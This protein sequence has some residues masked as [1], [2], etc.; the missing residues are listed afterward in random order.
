M[1]L[2]DL[3]VL[4]TSNVARSPLLAELLRAAAERRGQSEVAIASAGVDA[5]VGEPA[6]TGSRR[7]AQALGISLEGH[8]SMPVMMVDA[9]GASLVLVMSRAHRTD[10][11]RRYPDLSGRTFTLREL[12]V[13]LE[14]A[15]ADGA[16]ARA[17]EATAPGSCERLRAVAAI[18]HD[19]RPARGRRRLDIP[20]PIRA[21]Q[22]EYDALGEEFSRACEALED[23]LFGPEGT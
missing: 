15:A 23:V 5:S 17:V 18:A 16:L 7:V 14:R 2:T 9:A 19:R 6:A 12:L 21:G 13:L 10:V 11:G 3:L 20:D 22:A 1:Q 4:C 8:R